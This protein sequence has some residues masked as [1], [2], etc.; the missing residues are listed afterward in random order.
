VSE[1]VRPATFTEAFLA[2]LY[3]DSEM[4]DWL[5]RM[6]TFNRL[7]YWAQMR[8]YRC[9]LDPGALDQRDNANDYSP[10]GPADDD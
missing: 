9:E 10:E 7:A 8:R 2:E 4:T 6:S 1:R 5:Y 3:A